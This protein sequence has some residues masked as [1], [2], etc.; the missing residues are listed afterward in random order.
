[1]QVLKGMAGT[2][3]IVLGFAQGLLHLAQVVLPTNEYIDM[4]VCAGRS[5][6]L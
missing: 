5:D 4:Q 6:I 3:D 1:M 2:N